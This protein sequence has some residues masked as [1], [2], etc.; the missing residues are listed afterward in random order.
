ML[1]LASRFVLPQYVDVILHTSADHIVLVRCEDR[2]D[3]WC[4]PGGFLDVGEDLVAAAVQKVKEKTSL[5]LCGT[6]L[7]NKYVY[8]ASNGLPLGNTTVYYGAAMTS[9]ADYGSVKGVNSFSLTALPKILPSHKQIISD[10]I[11][12]LRH[13][14]HPVRGARIID[15][16]ALEWTMKPANSH[17]PARSRFAS[18]GKQTQFLAS[19]AQ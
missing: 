8:E 13:D 12:F 18:A 11:Q 6:K 2:E 19:R 3:G 10:Y 5:H 16:A 7:F 4:L 1:G 9:A 14:S 17:V 15:R